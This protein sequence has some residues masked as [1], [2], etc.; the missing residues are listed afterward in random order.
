MP[1]SPARPAPAR[2][3]DDCG[4]RASRATP[5]P[6]MSS[7]HAMLPPW[8]HRW[9]DRIVPGAQ[10]AL[11]VL[12]VWLLRTRRRRRLS[13]HPALPP[14]LTL[15]ARRGSGLVIYSTALLLI[16]WIGSA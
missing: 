14:E 16:S 6:P 2:Y 7:L 10:I 3:R 9:L 4:H 1:A 5:T 13:E 8:A 11:I 15:L 12:A